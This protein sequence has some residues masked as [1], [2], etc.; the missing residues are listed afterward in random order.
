MSDAMKKEL[1]WFS[2]TQSEAKAMMRNTIVTPPLNVGIA[3][4]KTPVAPV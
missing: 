3:L 4:S 1:P 2:P